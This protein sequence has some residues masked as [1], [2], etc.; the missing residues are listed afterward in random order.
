MRWRVNSDELVVVK[1]KLAFRAVQQE[2]GRVAHLRFGDRVLF[3]GRIFHEDEPVG[4]AVQV[5]AVRLPYVS[6]FH[7]VA[8]AQCRRQVCAF[9]QISK[10]QFVQSLAFT[11]LYKVDLNDVVR[12]A[13]V[14]DLQTFFQFA[15]VD[16]HS[17]SL[18][19]GSVL[20]PFGRHR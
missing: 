3:V 1:Q 2:I 8:A 11:W 17:E 16:V 6:C 10:L 20:M 12:V 7:A 14:N 15:R 13:F 9:N 5:L 18:V 19:I 4:I